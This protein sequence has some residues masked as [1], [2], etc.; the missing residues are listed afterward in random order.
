PSVDFLWKV[1][2]ALLE[3]DHD[4][5]T[6]VIDSVTK[7]EDVFVQH[8]IDSDHKKPKSI[9]QAAGGYGAGAA[10]VGAMHL[11]LRKV[12]EEIKR[13]KGCNIVFIAHANVE[14]LDLPDSDPF[15]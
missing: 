8:V 14:N 13:K 4:Y 10:T 2:D 12:C 3:E 11:R 7:L 9:N 5:K 15:M 6:V 1:M